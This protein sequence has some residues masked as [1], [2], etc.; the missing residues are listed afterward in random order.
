MDSLRGSLNQNHPRF[1]A[2][3]PKSFDKARLSRIKYIFSDR[4]GDPSGFTFYFVGNINPDS[5][6]AEILTYLGGMPTVKREES[7]KDL[8]ARMP[9]K[10]VKTAYHRG[11]KSPKATVFIAYTGVNKYQIKERQTLEAVKEYL[12]M[13]LLETLREDQGGTYGASVFFQNKH[14]P[15]SEYFMGV[16]FDCNPAK[17]DTMIKIVYDEVEKLKT[18]GPDEKSINNI[19]QNKLKDYKE[20]IKENSYWLS[21]I[22]SDD[23]NDEE[24]LEFDYEKFW[25]NITPKQVQ[26]AAKKYLNEG[27]VIQ[28][29]TSSSSVE[30]L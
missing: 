23:M 24:F 28:L 9:D 16:Y 7:Y 5:V 15:E 2:M 12:N 14:Y 22:M 20:D 30:G 19:A 29:V 26:K 6:K 4:F 21:H 3:T 18:N 25:T 11:L 17:L 1:K 10:V 13:R 8:G 27:R